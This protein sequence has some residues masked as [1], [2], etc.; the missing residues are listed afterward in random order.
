MTGGVSG[1]DESAAPRL[2]AR[3]AAYV[4]TYTRGTRLSPMD[5]CNNSQAGNERDDI[6]IILV[7]IIMASTSAPFIPKTPFAQEHHQQAR[8]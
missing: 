7:D 2:L 4:P 3:S 6:T 1:D 5:E 8:S